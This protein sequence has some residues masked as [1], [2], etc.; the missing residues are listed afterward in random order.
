MTCLTFSRRRRNAASDVRAGRLH[1][2]CEPARTWARCRRGDRLSSRRCGSQGMR[3][4]SDPTPSRSEAPNDREHRPGQ[5]ARKRRDRSFDDR[6]ISA[7]WFDAR[8]NLLGPL[9]DHLAFRP[10]VPV[11]SARHL[12]A[13]WLLQGQQRD[14]AEPVRPSREQHEGLG[15]PC[16][17]LERVA[18]AAQPLDGPVERRRLPVPC[19]CTPLRERR[20]GSAVQPRDRRRRSRAGSDRLSRREPSGCHARRRRS[21]TPARG[22]AAGPAP[23]RE[24]TARAPLP[25]RASVGQRASERTSSSGQALSR[26]IVD[27][28][29]SPRPRSSSPRRRTSG[30][31]PSRRHPARAR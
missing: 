8:T 6:T 9:V 22:S 16:R 26:S 24:S 18:E 11:Q 23:G 3:P 31:R 21:G 28:T 30:A 14:H 5:T 12:V 25:R 13:A 2:A 19:G 10:G 7:I 15:S 29:A 27:A 4:R 1:C 17:S 20:T